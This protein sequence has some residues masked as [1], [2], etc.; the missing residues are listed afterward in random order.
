MSGRGGFFGVGVPAILG[1]GAPATITGAGVLE[2]GPTRD[3]EQELKV[4]SLP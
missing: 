4:S 3:S 2:A 1:A